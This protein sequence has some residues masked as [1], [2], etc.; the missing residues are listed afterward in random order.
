MRR[1]ALARLLL[2]LERRRIAFP[3]AQDYAD[4]QGGLQQRFA[5][6]EMVFNDQFALSKLDHDRR[7]TSYSK[8]SG[9]GCGASGGRER[10]SRL[11]GVADYVTAGGVEHETEHTGPLGRA[12]PRNRRVPARTRFPTTRP[13]AP[14]KLFRHHRDR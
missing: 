8:Q 9:C 3:K 12:A 2:A 1:R 13:C 14:P 11:G 5:T 4:L 6:G 7:S 10:Q